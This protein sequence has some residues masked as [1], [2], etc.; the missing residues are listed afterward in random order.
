MEIIIFSLAYLIKGGQFPVTN[1]KALS[2]LLVF[3]YL[4][5]S[6]TDLT[7]SLLATA[8][9]LLAIAPSMGEEAGAI[10]RIGHW[11]GKYKDAGFNRSYGVL[12]GVQRGAWM[13]AMFS[14]VMGSAS[15]FVPVL[16]IGFVAA[17]FIGQELYFRL[18]GRDDWKYSEAILGALIG[19]C[20]HIARGV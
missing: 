12:K 15:L 4:I 19:I 13:G 6:T 20:I 3:S 2:A 9:W 17:H 8:A 5:N 18:N 1:G 16:A 10:G 11:W 14:I 7:L